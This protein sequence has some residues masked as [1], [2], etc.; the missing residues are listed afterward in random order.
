MRHLKT[1]GLLALA[2]AGLLAIAANASA[3]AGTTI[4]SP[5]GTV[6]TPTIKAES[7]GGH[8]KLA[9]PIA[10]IECASTLEAKVERHGP[11]SVAGGKVSSLA[12][13]GCTNL[14][15]VTTV[16][17]GELAIEWTSGYNGVVTSTGMTINATRLGVACN[18]VTSG[19]P[20]GTITG[21]TPATIHL[22]AALPSHTGSSGL[23]GSGTAKLEGSYK[24]SSPESLFVDEA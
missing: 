9:N 19:T 1:L 13:T 15:H 17:P 4:T 11:E 8:L 18:Y 10:T 21:G 16:S 6:A 5:T 2:V 23:C 22:Q 7:E 20:I 14:W 3:T 24:L 12:F